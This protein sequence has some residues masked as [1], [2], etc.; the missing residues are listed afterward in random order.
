VAGPL[1]H[2]LSMP[3]ADSGIGSLRSRHDNLPARAGWLFQGGPVLTP[4]S[5]DSVF[6]GCHAFFCEDRPATDVHS[7]LRVAVGVLAKDLHQA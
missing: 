5:I 6:D 7:A 3:P 1:G 4:D 2:M